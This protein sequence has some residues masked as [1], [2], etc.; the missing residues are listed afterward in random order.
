MRSKVPH[1]PPPPSRKFHS[2]SFR[3][4]DFFKL[5][6]ISTKVTPNGIENYNVCS[7]KI[8]D[9]VQNVTPFRCTGGH[10]WVTG[11][12]EMSAQ[13][14][15]KVTLNTPIHTLYVPPPHPTRQ[16]PNV[17]RFRSAPSLV[18]LQA[19]LRKMHWMTFKTTR[20]KALLEARF[21]IQPWRFWVAVSFQR[22]ALN[23]L[24]N[25]LNTTRSN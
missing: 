8:P 17:T 18:E 19:I 24:K 1:I 23:D 25:T 15:P 11:H 16:I 22:S 4:P 10:F 14:D 12:F 5:N 13:N 21:P 6:A 2:A 7:T 3:E 9:R 20:S